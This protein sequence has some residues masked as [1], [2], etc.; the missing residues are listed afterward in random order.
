MYHLSM[1]KSSSLPKNPICGVAS[2]ASSVS[3]RVSTPPSVA[4][5]RL[6]YGFFHQTACF[7]LFCVYIL[8]VQGWAAAAQ[9]S[10]YSQ[11]KKQ[12]NLERYELFKNY[13]QAMGSGEEEVSE[14]DEAG[15]LL[16]NMNLYEKKLRIL[17]TENPVMMMRG[18]A[19]SSLSVFSVDRRKLESVR[20]FLE[21]NVSDT[22]MPLSFRASRD[23]WSGLDESLSEVDAVIERALVENSL[24]IYDG[25]LWQIALTVLPSKNSERLVELHTQ[26]LAKGEA[27]Q[28]S[29]LRGYGPVFLYGD[30][31]KMM[32]R[33][34]GFFFRMISDK[35][36]QEDPL[37]H[38]EVPGYPNF[39]RVHH[40]DWKPITGEQAWAAIIGPLQVAYLK[41]NGNIPAE[42]QELKLALSILPA[43]EAM[44][45]PLGA[46]Y[47]APKG[48]FGVHPRLI[49]VENNLSVYA[50]LKMLD[51]VLA[52]TGGVE[53]QRV[54]AM[55]EKLD[56]FF[57]KYAYNRLTNEFYVG[58][59]YMGGGFVS[60]SLFS[61]DCQSWA[62]LALGPE[63]IDAHFGNGES[64]KILNNTIRQS[65]L[66]DS[67]GSLQGLGFSCDHAAL[68]V[69]WTCGAIMAAR[70]T[71]DH[72]AADKPEW[73][74]DLLEKA[75]KMR[76]GIENF[77]TE[78]SGHGTA[79]LYS[80]DR[81]FIPFGWWANAIPSVASSAWVIFIDLYFNPFQ[82]GGGTGFHQL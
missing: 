19:A 65:C 18:A 59:F 27:G 14:Q 1:K 35:Y 12:K 67:A 2:G 80:S 68:S 31:E 40:E 73:A 7:L 57:E 48:T 17:S 30:E 34:S 10:E 58:G 78:L 60:Q 45:S 41:Y 54:K 36:L 72:Y 75:K 55:L 20:D 74:Q 29:D 42:S 6:A 51:D 8:A 9:L 52:K 62:I 21:S 49:S 26:R 32:D 53:R 76:F 5:S 47:H 38:N 61:T 70:V 69:E 44:Q 28:M 33:D 37:G 39:N 24:N 66:I 64:Y 22:A 71:A 81:Y 15:R 46:L 13:A 56:A 25:A 77:K 50:A 23:Y 82:L 63:W 79:Y 16:R 43:L 4:W 3:V 11:E